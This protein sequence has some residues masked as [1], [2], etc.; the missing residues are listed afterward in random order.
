MHWQFTPY[1]I[2]Y[3]IAAAISLWLVNVAWWRRFVLGA[4]AFGILMFAVA[5]W[6]LGIVLALGNAGFPIIIIWNNVPLLGMVIVPPALL[7]FSL[8]YTGR[9]RWLSLPVI[10]LLAIEP[11]ITLL[12]VWT[13]S[14]YGLIANS[15]TLNRSASFSA[16]AVAYGSW[17]WINAVYSY[18]LVLLST[19]LLGWFILVRI[20]S[21]SLYRGQVIALLIAIVVPWIVTAITAFGWHPLPGL[22]LTPLALTITGLALYWALFHYRADEL[23]PVARN[24][25]VESMSDA[26]IVTDAHHRITDL[27]PQAERLIGRKLSEVKGQSSLRAA[28]AFSKLIERFYNLSTGHEELALTIDGAHRYFDMS[29][30][31]LPERRGSPTGRLVVLRDVTERRM[32]MQAM[33]QARAAA[34]SANEAK[35][36]FLAMM[37]H[38]IRTP[39][40]AIIGMTSLLLDTNL[41]P[42]QYDYAETIRSSADAL[43]TIINDI[44]DFS[45]IE[46]GKLE[47]ETV[48]FD[49]RNAVEET[50]E[51]LAEKARAKHLE[52]ASLIYQD[53]PTALR[54]DPGR[55]RQV[56]TNLVSNALK[57]TERG[58]VIV[59]G[60]K[61]S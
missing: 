48:D 56:L 27:N 9:S 21:D 43:L 29:I 57:F 54:G 17:F 23:V 47:F 42:E 55:L 51:L 28:P 8:Q 32:A 59:R 16:Q 18:L 19:L 45:K 58:E 4:T 7:A 52:F 38:E 12:L 25:V 11:M 20:R 2:P 13:N 50:I 44:L 49:L 61:E 6:S 36:A 33:E 1:E 30:S 26:V 53:V 22:D 37:S 41:T 34:E 24:I 35:S 31:S 46:A 14:S 5:E 15:T 40:N 60:E 39:M 3:A 10:I